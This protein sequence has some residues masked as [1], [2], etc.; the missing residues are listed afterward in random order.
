MDVPYRGIPLQVTPTYPTTSWGRRNYTR[1]F[2]PP[3]N[4]G[5]TRVKVVVPFNAQNI[6]SFSFSDQ[7][8]TITYTSPH[9]SSI[10]ERI[11]ENGAIVL[12]YNY[13]HHITGVTLYDDV[14]VGSTTVDTSESS[15]WF[16][17]IDDRKQATDTLQLI[18]SRYK[19]LYLSHSDLLAIIHRGLFKSLT[20]TDLRTKI[21]TFVIDSSRMI[22]VHA[23]AAGLNTLN[24]I[25]P[26]L[27]AFD[28]LL[29]DVSN[30]EQIHRL[31]TRAL[32]RLRQDIS[33]LSRGVEIDDLPT[34]CALSTNMQIGI[35]AAVATITAAF[36]G[37]K[38]SELHSRSTP[39]VSNIAANMSRQFAAIYQ[40]AVAKLNVSSLPMPEQLCIQFVF[41]IVVGVIAHI[42]KDSVQRLLLQ[43]FTTWLYKQLYPNVSYLEAFAAIT[44]V[45]ALSVIIT[46][47]IERKEKED[48]EN[49]EHE[50]GT[51]PIACADLSIVSAFLAF[52][53]SIVCV[54]F[55]VKSPSSSLISDLVSRAKN[56]TT[57]QRMLTDQVRAITDLI[58]VI[59]SFVNDFAE[60]LSPSF[61]LMIRQ[62]T[63]DTMHARIQKFV[64]ESFPTLALLNN[65]SHK[66][67][68]VEVLGKA[69]ERK[70]F[71]ALYRDAL[72]TREV[73]MKDARLLASAGYRNLLKVLQDCKPIYD[74][75]VVAEGMPNAVITPF[76][77]Y[78]YGMPGTGKS[79]MMRFIGEHIFGTSYSCYSLPSG[80][81]YWDGYFPDRNTLVID[82]MGNASEGADICEWFKVS[83]GTPVILNM[84]GMDSSSAGSGKG[85]RFSSPLILVASNQSYPKVGTGNLLP[86][87]QAAANRRRHLCI[88][89]T[90]KQ[91]F[92][93]TTTNNVAWSK[94]PSYKPT[95]VD[96]IAQVYDECLDFYRYDPSR[97]TNV[98]PD[99]TT[100]LSF[101]E[102]LD[103]ARDSFIKHID[104]QTT[105]LISTITTSV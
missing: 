14:E 7:E 44:G 71:I 50:P 39:T 47:M 86:K 4:I 36:I 97:I 60:Y 3:H 66:D 53:V 93:D 61:S 94:A 67:V 18:L 98:T 5:G 17:P 34:A 99:P 22:I 21:R 51:V 52:F 23:H 27:T 78:L 63:P 91:G 41:F 46:N 88:Y 33:M 30:P 42:T 13:Y 55:G 62:A 12:Q 74:V 96:N 83:T 38:L 79:T 15:H 57:V 81:K 28:R 84:A 65:L 92:Y 105:L 103:L 104:K 11:V 16:V 2:Y 72:H 64:T 82:D 59:P 31:S 69:A 89:V 100:K 26:E 6:N 87:D 25:Q 19:Y 37:W 73:A 48:K 58:S 90:P 76:T 54:A 80:N 32:Q 9:L 70:N 1:R 56:V 101:M 20:D 75:A 35:G 102:V 10:E 49:A 24:H 85:T 29:T 8:G 45:N 77:A 40:A 95:A 43:A 68:V